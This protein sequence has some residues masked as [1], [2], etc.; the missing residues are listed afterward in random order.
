MQEKK[1][2]FEQYEFKSWLITITEYMGTGKLI[3]FAVP[4]K[5]AHL[6]DVYNYQLFMD[7]AEEN[8]IKFIEDQEIHENDFDYIVA[9]PNDISV[10]LSKVD[11]RCSSSVLNYLIS[12]ILCWR[13]ELKQCSRYC[14]MKREVIVLKQINRKSISPKTGKKRGGFMHQAW[15]AMVKNRDGKCVECS[16]VYD[17]HAHHIKQVKTHYDLRYDVNNGITMCGPCHRE[18]HKKNG[19]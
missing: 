1:E 7:I 6:L 13:G 2:V 19:R 4:T 15:A 16:S 17:L 10:S 12:E 5:Y 9:E 11:V 18:W 3:G 8:G 14:E